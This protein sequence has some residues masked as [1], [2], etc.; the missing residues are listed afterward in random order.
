MRSW[1]ERQ[2]SL[3]T[4]VL[5]TS[6]PPAPSLCSLLFPSMPH[7]PAPGP[8]F[9]CLLCQ[10]LNMGSAGPWV[11]DKPWPPR[12]FPGRLT[13]SAHPSGPAPPPQPSAAALSRL[14]LTSYCLLVYG[15]S[16]NPSESR[17]PD[18]QQVFSYYLL[19][20]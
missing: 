10:P 20:E 3:L 15:L 8:C 9:C 14:F 16:T 19:N 18:S 7:G 5:V 2:H 17:G 13:K 6:R 11:Q 1:L 4:H 12:G